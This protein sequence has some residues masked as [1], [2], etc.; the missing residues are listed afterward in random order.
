MKGRERRS[1]RQ[2]G[3][4]QAEAHLHLVGHLDPPFDP[5]HTSSAT[6]EVAA[7]SPLPMPKTRRLMAKLPVAVLPASCTGTVSG[8]LRPLIVSWPLTS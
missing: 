7:Q 4:L 1:L 3:E 5:S 6:S 2:A 8:W